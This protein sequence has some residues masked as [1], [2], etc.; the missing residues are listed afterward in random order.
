VPAAIAGRIFDPFFT[1]RAPGQGTGLGLHLS[2]RIVEQHGGSLE[3]RSVPG[4]GASFHIRLPAPGST[5]PPPPA[6]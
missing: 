1:T 5:V 2:R 6:S 4:W 3:L